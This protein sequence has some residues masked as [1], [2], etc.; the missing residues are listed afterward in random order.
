[1][2]SS[3]MMLL[4]LGTLAAVQASAAAEPEFATR[5]PS[6]RITAVGELPRGPASPSDD[7]RNH[8][9]VARSAAGR[10]VEALG[11]HVTTEQRVGS[12]QAVGFAGRFD[13]LTSAA[14]TT[15]DGNVGLFEGERLVAIVHAAR[16]GVDTPRLITRLG[17]PGRLRIWGEDNSPPLADL[18][19]SGT[20]VAIVPVAAAD[21]WCGGAVTVP[22]AYSSTIRR[23][24]LR[25]IRAGW[26][27]SPP[28]REEIMNT[29]YGQD[30]ALRRAGVIE[31]QGCSGTGYALCGFRYR[32]PRGTSLYVATVGEEQRIFSYEVECGRRR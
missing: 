31:T 23:A 5:L 11:W 16:R 15:D 30:T 3:R 28:P 19:V 20:G 29:T 21:R 14:C 9:I 2:T 24:R 22:N 1:M 4:V 13:A 27:P 26:R 18:A 7:C 12:Y 6:L 17:E 10:V 32:H 25:L 8:W